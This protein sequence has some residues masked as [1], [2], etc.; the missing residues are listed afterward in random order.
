[1]QAI[2]LTKYGEPDESLRLAEIAEPDHPK[3]GQILIR[4]DCLTSMH[5]ILTTWTG[6]MAENTAL[7]GFEMA[8]LTPDCSR[9]GL[10]TTVV[11][12]DDLAFQAA[13]FGIERHPPF[14]PLTAR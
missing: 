7:S 14:R 8:T 12:P 2:Q 4:V 6:K 1:M 10:L 13:T 5:Q 9:E 3:P 11:L